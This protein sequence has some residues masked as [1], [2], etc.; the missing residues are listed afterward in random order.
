MR[1]PGH[2]ARMGD[3]KYAHKC[4]L[5]YPKEKKTNLVKLNMDEMKTLKRI[6]NSLLGCG[7]LPFG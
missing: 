3:I 2:V 6:L 4:W 1:L 5:E 7:M